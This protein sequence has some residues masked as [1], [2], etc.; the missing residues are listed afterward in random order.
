MSE[1]VTIPREELINLEDRISELKDANTRLQNELTKYMQAG[2]FISLL[3]FALNNVREAAFLID[4]HAH[5]HFVNEE[6]CRILGYSRDELLTMS[7]SDV[8]PDFPHACWTV[9]WNDLRSHHTLTFEGR[10]QTKEGHIFPVE[11]NANYLE[12]DNNGYNLALV[13]DITER[14]Q[15]ESE[16]LTY[17]HFLQHMDQINHALM[18]TDNLED[19]MTEALNT[20]LSIL[21]CDRAWI[22]CHSE[23]EAPSYRVLMECTQP[24]YPGALATGLETPIDPEIARILRTVGASSGPVKFGPGSEHPLPAA[25][26]EAFNVQSQIAMALYPKGDTSYIFGLHQ[27]SHPR[28]WTD[29]E[30]TLFR[31]VGRRLTDSLNMLLMYRNLQV[32]E[33]KFRT[34]FEESFDGLFIT[35]PS[36]KILEMNRKGIE[37]FGYDTKDE[38]LSLDLESDIYAYPPDRK[39]I[40]AMVNEQGSAEYEV[41][42]KKKSGEKMDT[43][44]ALTAEKDETGTILAY[45]GIIRDIT[46]R[47]RREEELTRYQE[48]LEELV[49]ERTLR[50]EESEN[51]YHSLFTNMTEGF[52]LHEIICNEKGEPCDYR[53]IEV[54]PTFEHLTGLNREDLISKTVYEIL[55]GNEPHWIDTYG[56]V[57]LTGQPVHFENR[58]AALNR[59]YEV[60]A[61]SPVPG[62]FATIFTDIT[63]RKHSEEKIGRLNKDLQNRAIALE[64]VNEELEAFVYSVSHDLRAPLRHIDGFIDLLRKKNVALMDTQSQHYMTVISDSS[65]HMGTMIDDLLSFSRMNR[66]E[67]I[68]TPVNLDS[69]L[70]EVLQSLEFETQGRNIC[71]SIARLP[72]VTGDCS[73]LRIVFVNLIS[74]ALKFTKKQEKAEIEIG[75]LPARENEVVIFVRDNGVGFDMKYADKLFGVFQ[76]L[77]RAEE[78]EGTGI[79]LANIR[80]II[81]R[82]GGSTWAEGEVGRGAAVYFSLPIA[83]K[84]E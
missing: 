58:S 63:E 64:A 36:G 73:M 81:N 14:K 44:C 70:R 71:W 18:K 26:V 77:H 10:H 39:R 2:K 35:S 7:V 4:E 78:F 52:A 23:P 19:M 42:V 37:M 62:Q 16:R 22:V 46:K 72:A 61:Y 15:A 48:T 31:E 9:H 49:K 56:S 75:S 60:Y 40:L 24:E 28:I 20:L 83:E 51:L 3:H 54:N 79:G 50:L 47:K 69:L 59:N 66:Q 82:H 68:S 76:R 57:A 55:P 25:L 65:S 17:F 29:E 38:I 33:I 80:R 45:R 13:R 43:L 84:G 32:S 5:F 21:R 30:V 53:F 67:M 41:A 27:C 12:Y 11:I 74:N 6:S 1:T 8:D 34:L